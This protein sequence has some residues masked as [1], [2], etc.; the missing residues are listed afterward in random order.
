MLVAKLGFCHQIGE[1]AC[2]GTPDPVK[3]KTNVL[4]TQTLKHVS[5]GTGSRFP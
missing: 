2:L 5:G 3:L 1:A 4:D